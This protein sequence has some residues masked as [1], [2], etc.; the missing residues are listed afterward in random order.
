MY[1]LIIA[2]D[3]PTIRNG[4]ARIIPTFGLP[5]EVA[6]TAADGT[7]AMRVIE[8]I[9]PE[10][11]LLDI[12]MPH[13]SGLE[14]LERAIREVP[15]SKTV[16]ISGY[17]QFEYARR[18]L[19]LGVFDYLLKPVNRSVLCST[20]S[21]AV[22]SLDQRQKELHQ[23]GEPVSRDTDDMLG[24]ALHEIHRRYT[25]PAL[26]LSS[27]AQSMHVSNAYLSRGIKERTGE[28]FSSYVTRLRM[29]QAMALLGAPGNVPICDV[30]ERT[31]YASQHYFS[32]SFKDYTGLTPSEFRKQ[33]RETK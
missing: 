2:D 5:V 19:Q 14:L 21:A 24:A 32:H 8:R 33:A 16:I 28:T 31:G 18:A 13:L 25:D 9:R 17:D 27:L 20:L 11:M 1:K 10:L 15:E 22:K 7:E 29:E 12:N 30:A 4:L 6:G 26:S 3:G 23:L